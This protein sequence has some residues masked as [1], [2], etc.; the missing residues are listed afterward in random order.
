M[1]FMFNNVASPNTTE[2]TFLKLS[3]EVMSRAINSV[4][5]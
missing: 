1:E 5:S 4:L 2:N 3:E